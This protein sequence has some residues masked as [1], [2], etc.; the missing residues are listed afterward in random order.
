VTAHLFVLVDA[1]VSL[2]CV[3]F[4]Y[5]P[6]SGSIHVEQAGI[7]HSCQYNPF[8]FQAPSQNLT[9]SNASDSVVTLTLY[10]LNNIEQRHGVTATIA[11]D[12]VAGRV[13]PSVRLS[14]S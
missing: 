4:W 12:F 11:V 13:C 3:R 5:L 1:A 2:P 6:V 14:V 7:S 9:Q 8:E 10:A